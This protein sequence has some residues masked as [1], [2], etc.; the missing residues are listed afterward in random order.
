[1]EFPEDLRFAKS[2]EWIRVQDDGEI[3]MGI[4]DF[5]Q[6]ALGDVVY[7]DLPDVGRT[8]E[9]G[10]SLAEVESTKSVNDV[11]A[12]I[13]ATIVAINEALID[14]PELVNVDPYG[15]GWFVRFE[16]LGPIDFTGLL[17]AAAYRRHTEED[18]EEEP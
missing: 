4:S 3:V 7:I 6:D 16:P 17:D 8:V 1:V 18:S 5:A 2:H 9:A 12:P 13:G 11:Y 14:N 15:D 10:E